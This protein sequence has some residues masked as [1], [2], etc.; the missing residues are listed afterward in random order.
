M[1]E[2]S[3]IEWTE[4]TWNPL[5]GCDKC[6]AGCKFCYAIRTAWR[7]MHNP[8]PTI[9]AA[10]AGLVEQRPDGSLN[11]TGRINLLPERLKQPIAWKEPKKIFVNSQSDLFHV[12]VPDAFIDQV[13]AVMGVCP[14]HT[15]QVLTKRADRMCDYVR[16]LRER[17]ANRYFLPALFDNAAGLIDAAGDLKLADYL[18]KAANKHAGKN[19]FPLPNVH[20]GVSVEDQKAADERIPH[21]LSTPA[22]V[23]FLSCEPL[24]GPMDLRHVQHDRIVEIDAL[25]GDHG[26]YRPLQGRSDARVHWVIV[27]GESGPGAR[28]MHPDWARSLRDQCQAAGVPFLYKQWGEW[29]PL[30]P[31]LPSGRADFRGCR[32]VENTKG[33]MY[34]PHELA[35]NGGA[36]HSEAL[37]AGH[38]KHGLTSMYPV[39]KKAAGRLLDGR[40]WNE[41]P[42]AQPVT[43]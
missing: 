26:V 10:Y 20:L 39:G 21:L 41:F 5:L 30:A 33:E 6:S 31:V 4:G 18:W 2:F 37:K 32:I 40:E 29:S 19:T 7:L 28:P 17:S 16:G 36:R 12:N 9:A 43:H 15:F 13:F 38:D 11:W 1:A 14:Q 35:F 22:A 24:L 42:T 8:N 25:T 23:R 27:G 34:E 3:P